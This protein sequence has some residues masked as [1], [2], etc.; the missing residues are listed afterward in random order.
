MLVGP[1]K[2]SGSERA[3]LAK[4]EQRRGFAGFVELVGCP[5]NEEAK[6]LSDALSREDATRP[7]RCEQTKTDEIE[8][9][10]E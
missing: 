6:L 8:L 5:D 1:R 10:E 4:L 3:L 2:G 9:A 7:A